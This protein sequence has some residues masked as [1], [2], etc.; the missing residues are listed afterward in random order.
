MAWGEP[1][2]EWTRGADGA[3]EEHYRAAAVISAPSS[4]PAAWLRDAESSGEP[5]GDE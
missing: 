2:L 3:I 4:P 1:V 5:E